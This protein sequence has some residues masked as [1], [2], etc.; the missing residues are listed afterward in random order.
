MRY[1]LQWGIEQ[2]LRPAHALARPLPRT[3]TA[4]PMWG[5]LE[6][7]GEW[8]GGRSYSL[9]DT[10]SNLH[11]EYNCVSVSEGPTT[12]PELYRGLSS[13]WSLSEGGQLEIREVDQP[14]P[15]NLPAMSTYGA[16]IA[17][18]GLNG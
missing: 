15:A 8:E 1:M 17:V 2:G 3:H 4:D 6:V 18:I 14:A 12:V 16:Q 10:V 9:S 5:M 7:A 11:G 13:A